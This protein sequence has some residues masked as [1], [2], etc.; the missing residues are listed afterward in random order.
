MDYLLHIGIVLGIYVM[1]A[2]SLNL[3]AGFA[4]LL[5]LAHAAFFG[6]GAYAAALAG[7]H[8]GTTFVADLGI[9]LVI[10]AG[11]G[12]LTAFVSLRVRDDYFVIATLAVQVVATS[13][14]NNWTALTGG[15]LGITSI[16]PPSLLTVEFT[17]KWALL[18][19]TWG[20]TLPVLAL[21]AGVVRSPFGRILA[22]IRED[23]VFLQSLGKNVFHAKVQVLAFSSG[24]AALAGAL[25]AHY[26]TF[27]DP[28]A[29]MLT[30]SIFIISIVILGGGGSLWGPAI[31]AAA[32]IGA[33]EALRF[34]GLPAAVA[35]NARQILYGLLLVAAMMWR[36]QGVLGA[37]ALPARKEAS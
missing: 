37:S 26:F 6:I 5:S 12:A 3:A 30:E 14:L 16:P 22:G 21:V 7:R 17:S 2:A 9:A 1:L 31:G 36:P 33:S 13:I 18:A 29:F 8:L 28:T 19:L 4:G 34:I 24:L 32:L 11:L 23:E 25:Y 15:P 20:L 35:G 27:I 10:G